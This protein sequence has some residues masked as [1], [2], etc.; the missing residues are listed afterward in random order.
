MSNLMQ[1]I[2]GGSQDGRPGYL[3]AFNYD[4]EIVETLK[5]SVPHMHREW[6]EEHKI[7]WVAAEYDAVLD[8]MFGNF[9]ALAHLQGSLF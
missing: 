5:R 7:W 6:R 9:N 8:G 3:I 4:V 2:K 1:C